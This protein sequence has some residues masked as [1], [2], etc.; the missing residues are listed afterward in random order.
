MKNEDKK[1][2]EVQGTELAKAANFDLGI[3]ADMETPDFSK[4]ERQVSIT[5]TFL[6]LP[7]IG[8]S[9]KLRYVGMTS[10]DFPKKDENDELVK[11]ENGEVVTESKPAAIFVNEKKQIIY[12]TSL[13]MIRELKD[14]PSKTDVEIEFTGTKKRAKIYAVYL[15][16]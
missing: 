1:A 16:N 6:D 11:N 8:D 7:K 12:H 14:V 3:I 2:N 13:Q 9:V 5:K 4:K 15:L 10:M